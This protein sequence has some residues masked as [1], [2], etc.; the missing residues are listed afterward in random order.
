MILA[1]FWINGDWVCLLCV[2]SFYWY[3]FLFKVEML[4]NQRLHFP[5]PVWLTKTSLM[6]LPSTSSQ[7]PQVGRIRDWM[8]HHRMWNCLLEGEHEATVQPTYII[9][10]LQREYLIEQKKI[11]RKGSEIKCVHKAIFSGNNT[12]E[13]LARNDTYVM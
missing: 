12:Y 4:E 2:T 5:G 11:P 8:S 7:V 6:K 9:P 13:V 1:V 3:L 10:T